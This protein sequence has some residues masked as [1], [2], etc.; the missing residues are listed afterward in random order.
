MTFIRT[1]PIEESEGKLKEIYD[2]EIE[3][4]GYIANGTMTLSLRPEVF[5][6]WE[7]LLKTIRSKMRLRRYELVTIA[8]ASALHCTYCLLAHGAVLRKQIF[9]AEQ[10]EAIVLDF[11]NAGLEPQEVAVMEFAEKVTLHA[12]AIKKEDVDKLSQL[13]LT[14]EEILDITLAASARNFWSKT[15]DALGTEADIKYLDLEPNVR[16]AMQKGRPFAETEICPHC[17]GTHIVKKIRMS[18]GRE[19]YYCP[20]CHMGG[21]VRPR[22]KYSDAQKLQILEY[23]ERYSPEGIR[24]MFGVTPVTLAKWKKAKNRG[25]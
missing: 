4:L 5:A 22:K 2:H 23:H 20:A 12:D 11:R 17:F 18:D 7:T 8:A 10:L 21:L 6:A 19:E 9:G 25:H 1:I 14:D 24:E 3:T 13:G 16:K 15:M